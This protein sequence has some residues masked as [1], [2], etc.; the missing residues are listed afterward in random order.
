LNRE[1]EKLERSL[2]GIKDMDGLP[3][4]LFIVD[5]GHEK[6]A[7]KE[8]T[9]LKIP[10]IGV[11]DSNNDPQNIDYIVPGNDDAIRAIS[12]YAKGVADA[13]LE[14]R[15]SKLS[16]PVSGEEDDFVEIEEGLGT[17]QGMAEDPQ[18]EE[19]QEPQQEPQADESATD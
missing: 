8:A 16:M 4:A 1:L 3:D 5:V 6:I 17:L 9:K 15:Q 11:V 19:M 13:V 2:G 7:V 18:T 12:L 10:V 14:A